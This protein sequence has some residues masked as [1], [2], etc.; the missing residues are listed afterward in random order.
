[1]ARVGT[2]REKQQ[3]GAVLR[4]A[5]VIGALVVAAIAV[6]TFQQELG[7]AEPSDGGRTA[8]A[9]L[10]EADRALAADDYLEYSAAVRVALVANDRYTVRGPVDSEVHS[11]IER[12]LVRHSA[13][14]EAWQIELEG[15]WDA[16]LHGD[17]EYWRAAHPGV[18]VSGE[19]PLAADDVKEACRREAAELLG[20]IL[21]LVPE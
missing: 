18:D 20:E 2:V 17:P 14:R 11:L 10:V 16:E 15:E 13:A 1:M 8:V 19:P 21:G 4:Y 12:A 6:T 5:V 9:A 3:G 7:L